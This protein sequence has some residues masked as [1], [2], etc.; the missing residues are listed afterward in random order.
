MGALDLRAYL[1][2]R[3]HY[4]ICVLAE[5]TLEPR[6]RVAGSHLGYDR[7]LTIAFISGTHNRTACVRSH[8][9]DFYNGGIGRLYMAG[10]RIDF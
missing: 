9:S 2:S 7:C 1:A 5:I 8:D 3:E 6:V 10:V 4:A